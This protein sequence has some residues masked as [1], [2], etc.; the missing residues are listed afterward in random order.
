MPQLPEGAAY[1]LIHHEDINGVNSRLQI[2]NI[3]RFNTSPLSG[4]SVTNFVV[5]SITEYSTYSLLTLVPAGG[6]GTNNATT[7]SASIV[8]EPYTSDITFQNS[9]YN[10]LL[11]NATTG[12]PNNSNKFIA[13]YVTDQSVPINFQAIRSASAALAT[14]PDSNYTSLRIINPRYNGSENTSDNY[15]IPNSS[16]SQPASIDQYDTCIYEFDWMGGGYPE[17]VNGGTVSLGN[18]LIVNSKNSVNVIKPSDS[19][20]PFIVEAN[21][22]NGT[23]IYPTPYAPGGK[24]GVQL[25]VVYNRAEA[26]AL[27]TYAIPS[28]GGTVVGTASF[29]KSRF[30]FGDSDRV[31]Y[32]V[33]LDSNNNYTMGST[34]TVFKDIKDPASLYGGLSASLASGEWRWF[35]SFYQNLPTTI[36]GSLSQ[37]VSS[38]FIPPIEITSA[39]AIFMPSVA[40]FNLSKEYDWSLLDGIDVGGA[41]NYGALIWPSPINSYRLIVSGSDSTS[42]SGIQNGAFTTQFPSQPIQENFQTITKTYGSNKT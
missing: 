26:P 42:F 13:D 6:G 32:Q 41:G 3:V 15:N 21:L 4:T 33:I 20:Y 30:E 23:V 2:N 22:P 19:T 36:T 40:Y 1:A 5:A 28:S 18:I 24:L 9:D 37:E 35:I 17:Y 31:L 11:N 10:V 12:R 38:S 29:S 39:E 14:T 27:A 8:L 25:N 7:I 16:G 34:E